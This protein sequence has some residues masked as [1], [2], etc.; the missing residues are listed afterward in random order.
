MR[1]FCLLLFV[2]IFVVSFSDA[3]WSNDKGKACK[4]T[5]WLRKKCPENSDDD[6]EDIQQPNTGQ[7]DMPGQQIQTKMKTWWNG[8]RDKKKD[9]DGK[10]CKTSWIRKCP[11]NKNDDT[12]EDQPAMTGE[13]E[14]QRDNSPGKDKKKC[15]PSIWNRKKCNDDQDNKDGAQKK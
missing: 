10:K 2:T 11:E 1:F 6:V 5:G 12:E 15:K 13:S 8:L 7:D 14:R 3:L 4:Q 9:K